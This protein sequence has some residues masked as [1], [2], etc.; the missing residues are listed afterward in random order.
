MA[1]SQFQFKYPETQVLIEFCRVGMGLAQTAAITRETLTGLDWQRFHSLARRHKV[2]PLLAEG[3]SRH[4]YGLDVPDEIRAWL[5]KRS[6]KFAMN[7]LARASEA[8]AI[9]R[10]L[11]ARNIFALPYKGASLALMAYGDLGMRS[12]RDI[13]FL[14]HL[15]DFN[16][17]CNLLQERGYCV[18]ARIPELHIQK[19]FEQGCEYNFDLWK[20]E[21]RKF[22][23][24]PHWLIGSKLHQI[25]VGIDF[26]QGMVEDGNNESLSNIQMTPSGMLLS[27]LLHHGGKDQWDTLK[28]VFDI[29]AIIHRHERS[30]DWPA[31]INRC[32]AIQAETLALAGLTLAC[33]ISGVEYPPK[34]AEIKSKTRKISHWGRVITRRMEG[35]QLKKTG[36]KV[37]F[38]TL[39]FHLS[40]RDSLPC[41]MK[42]LWFHLLKPFT[43]NIEDFE[44]SQ[45]EELSYTRLAL[46]KPLRLFRKYILT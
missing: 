43:P 9:S 35:E 29:A 45:A 5:E 20:D 27:L 34:L 12:S 41:K 23:V 18:Q 44:S 6:R 11:N 38:K 33:D 40:I 46:L 1:D 21:K 37:I 19:Y 39:W 28:Q 24:E 36:P 31:I 3:V 17:V 7:N 16:G 14:F 25:D 10:E 15:K 4:S 30:L 26:F 13:D 42:I 32:R 8:A 22:H 2:I